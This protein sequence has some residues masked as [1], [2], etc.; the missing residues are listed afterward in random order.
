MGILYFLP[1][2]AI[3]GGSDL[4]YVSSLVLGTSAPGKR[5][6]AWSLLP[7]SGARLS[8]MPRLL[9]QMCDGNSRGDY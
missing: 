6:N 8:T 1:L 9:L 3:G 2:A 5:A 4:I 7:R